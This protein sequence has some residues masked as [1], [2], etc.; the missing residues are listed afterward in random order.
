MVGGTKFY[1]RREIKDVM[2][3]LKVLVNPDDEVSWRRIVNVP[4]RGVGE[5]SVAKLAGWAGLHRLSFG[6]A[7]AQAPEVGVSG[8]AGKALVELSELLDVLRSQMAAP[9]LVDEN[10]EAL[11]PRSNRE[12][13]LVDE[14]G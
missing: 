10:G 3:Y 13:A 1:D 8:K 7:V 12:L 14:R 6:D 11:R 4:K 9:P 2:A 5:T